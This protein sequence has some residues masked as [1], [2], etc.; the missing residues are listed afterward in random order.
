MPPPLWGRKVFPSGFAVW[1]KWGV[2]L[3]LLCMEQ[4]ATQWLVLEK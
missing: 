3:H 1:L 2:C 4:D